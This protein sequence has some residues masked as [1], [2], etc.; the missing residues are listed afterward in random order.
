[1]IVV[2]GLMGPPSPALRADADAAALVVGGARHLADAQV[3]PE[4]R[5]VLGRLGPAVEA[6]A[7]LPPDALGVVIASGD[8]GLFGIV[9]RL[10]AAGLQPKVVPQPS[11]VSAAFAA[12]GLPWDDAEVVSCHG[13][14]LR[15]AAAVA[16]ACPKVA[17]MTGPDQGLRELAA[18]LADLDRSYVLAERLGEPDERVRIFTTDEARACP[19]IADPNIVLVLADPP[20]ASASAG[21]PG[22]RVGTPR[23]TGTPPLAGPDAALAYAALLPGI[24]DTLWVRGDRSRPVAELARRAQA[25]V[26]D[27]AEHPDPPMPPDLIVTD[28]LDLPLARQLAGTGWRRLAVLGDADPDARAALARDVPVRAAGEPPAYPILVLEPAEAP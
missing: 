22:D 15:V 1:M 19:D 16:R 27:L 17:V 12:V 11:S 25:A 26:I 13:R 7:A 28:T 6:L 5:F 18:A 8:P 23:D 14:P 4:R 2:H 21:P 3:P 24:G 10:R 20:Y 9:R